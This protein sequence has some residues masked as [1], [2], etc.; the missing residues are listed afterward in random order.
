MPDNSKLNNETIEGRNAVIE[1]L[2]ATG[3]TWWQI[4][5]KGIF[6]EK[7]NEIVSWTFIR[8]ESNFVNAVVVGAIAGAGGIGY[9]LYIT[10][11]FYINYHEVGL[12]TYLCLAFSVLLEV[13]ATKLRKNFAVHR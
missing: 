1:A 13:I 4:I 8:F 3:A 11:N 6:P 9:Q 2:R 5:F 10:A 7:L 12:I